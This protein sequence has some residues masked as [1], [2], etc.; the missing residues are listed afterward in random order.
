VTEELLTELDELTELGDL[1]DCHAGAVP[2]RRLN[3]RML[4]IHP[5]LELIRA[6]P[7][8]LGAA[9]AGSSSGSGPLWGLAT[10]ALVVALSV[11]RWFTTR[12]QISATQVQL[13][14]GLL[15]RTTVAAPLERVRTVD[16]T[17]HLLHRM[18]GLAKVVIGT[19][20][21][22]RRGR[23]GITLDGLDS[24]VAHRLRDELLHVAPAPAHQPARPCAPAAPAP[25]ELELARLDI[26]WLRYAPCTLSGAVTGLALLGVGWRIVS[27]SDI[28]LRKIGPLR[29]ATQYLRA[30]P[31]WLDVIDI[32]ALVAA[33]VAL[34]S[35][36]GYLLAFWNFRLTRHPGGTLQVTRGLLTS[37]ATSLERGRLRGVELSEPLLLRAVGGARCLAV[38]TG[39]RV[40][41][42]AERGGTLLLPP[43]PRQIAVLV[44]GAV[45]D[46]D[47]FAPDSPLNRPLRRH[48]PDARRRR[49]V[50]ACAVA[51]LLAGLVTIVV[52]L[53]GHGAAGLLSGPPL[54]AAG[55]FLAADRYRNL[56]HVTAGDYL[57]SR[58]GSVTRRHSVIAAEG[59][60]G[61]N[62][63]R[64]FFQRRVGLATL[65][66]TTAAGKQRYHL[67]DVAVHEAIAVA[68]RLSPGLL[69]G[70][71]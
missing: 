6:L 39:L 26:G 36:V 31:L 16:V 41:R 9:L 18:F 2:W 1:G 50:R 67:P 29:A 34:A 33:F 69:D 71:R 68:G 22:D 35:T 60:I 24:D 21:S 7:A 30:T 28:D 57:I 58:Y 59:I 55:A 42:G 43:A 37:R 52:G 48:G 44:G 53:T 63:R 14:R 17:S 65:T 47:P 61:W 45:L 23:G 62:V 12:Y 5:L 15:R 70:F 51:A 8:L 25:V 38:A 13:R 19:G 32:A 20:T 3:P 11:V 27:E 66:A 56:G 4:L 10:A 54:L 40:G 46:A 64:T 49:Y